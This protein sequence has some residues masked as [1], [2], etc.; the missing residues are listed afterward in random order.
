MGAIL[1]VM[2]VKIKVSSG[3]N[4]ALNSALINRK[5]KDSD[6]KNRSN[7]MGFF[8]YTTIVSDVV[9]S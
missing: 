3:D 6:R 4:V 9:L 5:K 1:F 7:L 2:V 8:R